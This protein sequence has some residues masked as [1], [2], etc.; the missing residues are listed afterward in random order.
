MAE[1]LSNKDKN[2][3]NLT[4]GTRCN[5]RAKTT[6]EKPASTKISNNNKKNKQLNKFLLYSSFVESTGIK[7]H[8][9]KP[10]FE[11]LTGSITTGTYHDFTTQDCSYINSHNI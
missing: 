11:K 2:H 9:K 6:G 1:A 5:L 4:K 3:K 8:E 10:H 7:L